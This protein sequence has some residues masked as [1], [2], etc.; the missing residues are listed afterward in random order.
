MNERDQILVLVRT[1]KVLERYVQEF[2][3]QKRTGNHDK[4]REENV[5]DG[6]HD[7]SVE[8]VEGFVQIVDLYDDTADGGDNKE[9]GVRIGHGRIAVDDLLDA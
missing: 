2:F 5:V 4:K 3:K 9:G 7:G 1:N 6:C 8:H